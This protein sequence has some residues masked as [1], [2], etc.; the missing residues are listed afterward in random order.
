[1]EEWFVP[2]KLSVLLTTFQTFLLLVVFLRD[3]IMVCFCIDCLMF[4]CWVVV[5]GC[6]LG[7]WAYTGLPTLE[8]FLAL[9]LN[10]T[11]P[12]MDCLKVVLY[13]TAV[14]VLVFLSFY[15]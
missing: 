11:L 8:T 7:I 1:M 15:V 10:A 14:L 6:V 13:I 12:L 5:G 2:H 4:L 3:L 9:F